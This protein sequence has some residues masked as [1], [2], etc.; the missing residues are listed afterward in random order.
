MKNTIVLIAAGITLLASVVGLILCSRKK[1]SCAQAPDQPPTPPVPELDEVLVAGLRSH[2]LLFLGLYEGIYMAAENQS[3]E[4]MDAYT[5]WYIRL[6]NLPEDDLFRRKFTGSFPRDGVHPEH[7]RKLLQYIRAAGI[8]RS[9]EQT[10]MAT[11]KTREQYIYMG[12]DELILG[13][14]YKVFRPCWLLDSV[15]VQQGL[16]IPME[17]M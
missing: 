12:A 7:L 14:E 6:G 10:H 9:R 1:T 17:G 11:D 8:C 16:L 5:E 4:A 3:P 13:K 15:T 2:A